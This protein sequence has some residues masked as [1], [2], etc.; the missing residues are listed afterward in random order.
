MW[1]CVP[2]LLLVL[3]L[4]LTPAPAGAQTGGTG[5]YSPFPSKTKRQRLKRYLQRLSPDARRYTDP[6]T[7]R[8]IAHGA[9]LGG[10]GPAATHPASAR[11]GHA[12]GNGIGWLLEL[13]LL[14]VPVGTVL[15]LRGARRSRPFAPAGE[16]TLAGASPARRG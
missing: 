1:R 5:L 7:R 10:V 16:T 6:L 2:C 3:V 13:L 12:P 14:A 4:G 9:F 15:V 11:A 8:Q